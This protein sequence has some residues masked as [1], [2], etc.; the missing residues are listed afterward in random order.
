[1]VPETVEQIGLIKVVIDDKEISVR[2]GTTILEA[3]KQLGIDIPVLCYHPDLKISGSCR[4]CVVEVEGQRTLQTACSFP[5]TQPLKVRTS[6][7][8][9]RKARRHILQMLLAD[10]VGDCYTCVRNGNCELQALAREYA[11][12][13]FVFG[14]KTERK[15]EIHSDE[16]VVRDMNKCIGCFRCIRTCSYVQ[17]VF[18]IGKHGRGNE[19][20][21]ATFMDRDMN[22]SLCVNCG[23]C[24]NRCPVAALS[25]RDDTDPIWAA[26]EDPTKHVVI[27]TA[28]AP[29]AGIGEGLGFPA[30]T[31]VTKRLNT[32]LHR[33]GF[34][35]VFDTNFTADLTIMEEGTELLLRLKAALVDGKKVS[36]PMLTSCSPGWVKFMEQVSPDLLD[37]VSTCK[38]PQQMFGAL[39][40]TYYAQNVNID[41]KDIVSVSLMPCSAKKFEAARP[42]MNASGHRDVDY[43]VTSRELARMVHEAGLDLHN[44]GDSE[45]DN[46]IGLGSGA[47][48]I[49][50]ATGGV[51]EAAIRTAYELVT[52]RPVPFDNL[53]IT[54]IRGMDGVRT[55]ELKIEGTVPAWSFLEGA[56]LK[57]MVCHGLS[58][59]RWM[60]EKLAAGELADYHFIELMAC[61]GG[62]LGGGGQ[63]IPTNP[64]IRAL[65]AKSI[66][67]EDHRMEYRKSHD[68]P[69][70]KKIYEE[71]LHEPNGHK[72]HVL[73]HTH[74]TK[75]GSKQA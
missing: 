17:S 73:L 31:A 30:G 36:L 7:P 54:P 57:V 50:G 65:R 21:I 46:P 52:G 28:P 66:Y 16:P 34:D 71:F 5:V 43:V 74:Y 51:M 53:D 75:R 41:P 6:T 38:S 40:K 55:A 64:E 14:R 8:A 15:Y 19:V 63:P 58:N 39:I 72:S 48:V 70:I 26:I 12:D 69:V 24:I 11:I 9:I 59:A 35:K 67:D 68:N 47:G 37:H 13:D 20:R 44:L 32:A 27:Q 10:H 56:T 3:A 60:L 1:M 18:A 33:M 61:P 62:C 23:Q 2:A 29:R 49:F 22:K 25:E 42:E 45:F 4:I